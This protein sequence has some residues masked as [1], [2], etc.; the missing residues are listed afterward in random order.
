MFDS[1]S[2]FG[3]AALSVPMDDAG[4]PEDAPGTPVHSFLTFDPDDDIRR[5]LEAIGVELDGGSSVDLIARMAA[6]KRHATAALFL[7]LGA[8]HEAEIAK[9]ADAKRDEMAIIA[10]HYDRRIEAER[11]AVEHFQRIVQEIA[12]IAMESGDFGKKKSASTPYGEFGVR[13]KS[14]TV[15]LSDSAA[16]LAHLT[17]EAPA[18]V[19]VKPTLSLEDAR[20]RFTDAELADA[21]LEPAW[22]LVKAELCRDLGGPLPPGVTLVPASRTAYAKPDVNI[23]NGSAGSVTPL[24]TL[25]STPAR[26]RGAA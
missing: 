6:S 8:E 5:D 26:M 18:F 15:E 7:R 11:R 12:T 9:L 17:A 22:S 14:A 24:S 4:V 1:T 13:D 16:L 23:V 10:A 19:K 2:M 21:K 25:D 3:E 20:E